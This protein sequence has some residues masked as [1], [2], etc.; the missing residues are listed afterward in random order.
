V[1]AQM[2][3]TGGSSAWLTP[4]GHDLVTQYRAIERQARQAAKQYLIRLQL[5][6]ASRC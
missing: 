6:R 2:G 4:L 1:T 5:S 3:G